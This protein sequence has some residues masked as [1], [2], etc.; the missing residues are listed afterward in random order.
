MA[1]KISAPIPTD[2]NDP[3]LALWLRWKNRIYTGILA[4]LGLVI[5]FQLLGWMKER[6]MRN[7]TQAVMEVRDAAS[8]DGAATKAKDLSGAEAQ[9]M[10]LGIALQRYLGAAVAGEAKDV[11]ESLSKAREIAGRIQGEFGSTLTGKLVKDG[12]VALRQESGQA[13]PAT[14]LAAYTDRSSIESLLVPPQLPENA[15]KVVLQT[16]LGK[17]EFELAAEQ[18]PELCKAFQE[19]VQSGAFEGLVLYKHVDSGR[20]GAFQFGDARLKHELSTEALPAISFWGRGPNLAPIDAKENGLFLW[21]GWVGALLDPRTAKVSAREIVVA[22]QAANLKDPFG[23]NQVVVP[24]A[25][26]T[27]DSMAVAEKIVEALEAIDKE[28]ASSTATDDALDSGAEKPAT[29]K[30][31]RPYFGEPKEAPKQ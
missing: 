2:P 22:T 13:A 25:R 18:A 29:A 27:G 4:I 5:V 1:Q 8:P 7:D 31:E 26:L 19:A 9:A 23:A 3:I 10:G 17:L 6:G 30:T 11:A 28:T 24:F 16:T 15:P 20:K 12:A 21:K 14:A